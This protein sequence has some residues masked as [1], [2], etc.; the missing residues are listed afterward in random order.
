MCH[1]SDGELPALVAPNLHHQENQH[2]DDLLASVEP[3]IH[4]VDAASDGPRR[5]EADL[6]GMKSE[7]VG[8][9]PNPLK[10]FYS[11]LKGH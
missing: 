8:R 6:R 9:E 3:T 10:L 5:D 2:G 1:G 11:S 4:H 7:D